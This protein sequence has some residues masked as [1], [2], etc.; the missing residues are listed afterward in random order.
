[1]ITFFSASFH[2]FD[3]SSR[4]P[5]RRQWWRRWYF[6]CR[7]LRDYYRRFH[8]FLHF[9]M[10]FDAMSR[11]EFSRERRWVID[12]GKIFFFE[13][14]SADYRVAVLRLMPGNIFTLSWLFDSFLCRV[15]CR[16]ANISLRLSIS[17]PSSSMLIRGQTLR[18]D[19]AAVASDFDISSMLLFLTSSIIVADEISLDYFVKY[20]S[21]HTITPLFSFRQMSFHSLITRGHHFGFR[22]F[23]YFLL[24]FFDGFLS[25][26]TLMRGREVIF[27]SSPMLLL[28]YF[29]F[30]A[31]GF[32]F[33]F[34]LSSIIFVDCYVSCI[35][36]DITEIFSGFW[37]WPFSIIWLQLLLLFS[38]W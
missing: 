18:R 7:L 3:F 29:I 8:R 1:M 32:I 21:S 35:D 16:G 27:A 14:V 28:R 19:D 12:A 26:W 24:F 38:L 25:L 17:S 36:I 5:C 30:G 22:L 37:W 10:S 20:F 13:A 23:R 15:S 33:H 31:A 6:H 11:S 34:L 9:L 2:D 4:F